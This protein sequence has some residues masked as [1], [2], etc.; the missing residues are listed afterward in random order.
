MA[1][2]VDINAIQPGLNPGNNNNNNININQFTLFRWF[3][4]NFRVWF[5]TPYWD[6]QRFD[7]KERLR[8]EVP[9]ECHTCLTETWHST[10]GYGWVLWNQDEEDILDSPFGTM[11]C[12]NN[13]SCYTHNGHRIFFHPF[14]RIYSWDQIPEELHERFR[15]AQIEIKE[16]QD[17]VNRLC[18][19]VKDRDAMSLIQDLR[20]ALLNQYWHD[21]NIP[22]ERL[23]D[24]SDPKHRK[25]PT[26]LCRPERIWVDPA[27][28]IGDIRELG[29]HILSL[30]YPFPERNND[31]DQQLGQLNCS[32]IT[33]SKGQIMVIFNHMYPRLGCWYEHIEG[34]C[35]YRNCDKMHFTFH[36]DDSIPGITR[37]TTGTLGPDYRLPKVAE[38]DEDNVWVRVI[39][40]PNVPVVA[41]PTPPLS[42]E[43]IL[44]LEREVLGLLLSGEPIPINPQ[45][46]PT[47]SDWS[48]IVTA[49][50]A[51]TGIIYALL[52]IIK[53]IGVQDFFPPN[54]SDVDICEQL[55]KCEWP[56]IVENEDPR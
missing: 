42:P 13:V 23:F 15:N 19:E 41:V 37:A 39:P 47:S 21:L 54:T 30:P 18:N 12:P 11:Q 51:P 34:Y 25:L 8:R 4:K 33:D 55:S 48:D 46:I 52:T 3:E 32:I 38:N 56:N 20:F 36:G 7:T 44:R 1:A 26:F 10:M 50:E 53:R 9:C 35:S 43:S 27:K 45:S 40:N 16:N 22:Y 2:R 24:G 5:G 49:D 14:I 28:C 31:F 17:R 29:R 6:G